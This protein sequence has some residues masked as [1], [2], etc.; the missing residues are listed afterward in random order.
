[1]YCEIVYHRLIGSD[2]DYLAVVKI[3][4]KNLNILISFFKHRCAGF[5]KDRVNFLFF[6]LFFIAILNPMVWSKG[7]RG[8]D[9]NSYTFTWLQPQF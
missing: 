6:F 5:G 3:T 2:T 7:S 4:L 8:A 1:M 9:F